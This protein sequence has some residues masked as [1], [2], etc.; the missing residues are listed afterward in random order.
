MQKKLPLTAPYTH[1]H[2]FLITTNVTEMQTEFDKLW[3][4]LKYTK[5][6]KSGK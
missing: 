5:T 1:V 4:V 3:Y 6:L 2:Y